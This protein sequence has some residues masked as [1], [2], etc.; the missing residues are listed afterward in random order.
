MDQAPGAARR[1][2]RDAAEIQDRGFTLA[3]ESQVFAVGARAIEDAVVDAG[4]LR[5]VLVDLR[6]EICRRVRYRNLHSRNGTC[7]DAAALWPARQR[8]HVHPRIGSVRQLVWK[9]GQRS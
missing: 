9:S 5:R 7:V 1:G 4:V 6:L 8:S 3:G 2:P